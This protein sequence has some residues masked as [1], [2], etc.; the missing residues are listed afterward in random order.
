[1]NADGTGIVKL[2]QNTT[3]DERIVEF[4]WSPDGSFLVYG[5]ASDETGGVFDLYRVAADGTSRSRVS[6]AAMDVR[7]RD[8]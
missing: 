3:V 5:A 1:M 8:W 4:A 7:V 2:T 6:D